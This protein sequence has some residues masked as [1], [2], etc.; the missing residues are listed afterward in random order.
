MSSAPDSNPWRQNEAG[1]A[2]STRLDFDVVIISHR[3]RFIFM[4]TRKTAGTSLEIALSA[5]CGPEDVITPIVPEDE[6]TRA[7]LGFPGPQ[8]CRIPLDR[9]PF[10]QG[11][12]TPRQVAAMVRRR[13]A[14]QYFNHIPAAQVRRAIGRDVWDSYFK[15]TIERNPFD[16]AVSGYWYYTKKKDQ[17]PK[18]EDFLL[19]LPPKTMSDWHIYSIGQE[20]AVDFVARQERLVHDL[21]L[22]SARLGINISMP[23]TRAKGGHRQDR[24][25]FSES[26]TPLARSRIELVCWRE[27]AAFGYE[28]QEWEPEAEL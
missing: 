24:R 1:D 23:S 25:H 13:K 26:L 18:L 4:K 12:H 22:L 2:G 28:W 19:G 20:I 17:R 10:G 5:H 8:N 16:K 6:A 11:Q 7:E 15:F 9:F 3:H 14:P 21:D 27:I